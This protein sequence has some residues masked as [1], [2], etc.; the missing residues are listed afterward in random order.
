MNNMRVI[1]QSQGSLDPAQM[2][3]SKNVKGNK[4][5]NSTNNFVPVDKQRQLQM[6]VNQQYNGIGVNQSADL[7]SK[8]GISPHTQTNFFKGNNT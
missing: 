6:M 7:T 1:S 5:R 8:P 4:V 3:Y 2:H